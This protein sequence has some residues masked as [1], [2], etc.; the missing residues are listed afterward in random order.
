MSS[1]SLESAAAQ[2]G[3]YGS[4]YA[5][6]E[7]HETDWQPVAGRYKALEAGS[8]R[9]SLFQRFLNG[10]TELGQRVLTWVRRMDNVLCSEKVISQ[11]PLQS[12]EYI[13]ACEQSIK[14]LESAWINDDHS[15]LIE[16]LTQ[17]CLC[18]R[19]VANM[20]SRSEALNDSS[21][22]AYLNNLRAVVTPHLVKLEEFVSCLEE[23]LETK[24]PSLNAPIDPGY[25]HT[26]L[27]DL[28]K[29]AYYGSGKLTNFPTDFS[30]A[31]SRNA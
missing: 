21:T 18:R 17:F 25:M 11:K 23:L 3:M 30:H 22:H 29:F 10:V 24:N 15:N 31:V 2:M 16:A 6:F 5:S 14:V 19:D 9:T 20:P 27:K 26:V 13:A 8:S 1:V 12:A 7:P 4:A 28:L